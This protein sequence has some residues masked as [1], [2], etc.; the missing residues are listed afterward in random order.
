MEA[1]ARAQNILTDDA[2]QDT[3]N[4]YEYEAF[5]SAYGSPTENV[6]QPFRFTGR[7]WEPESSL[8]YYRARSY[9][10]AAGRVLRETS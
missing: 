6:T 4:A 7:E 9:T 10:P 8:Y 1:Y 3:E 5:G 2:D